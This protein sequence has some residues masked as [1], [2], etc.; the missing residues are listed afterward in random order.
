M[1]SFSSIFKSVISITAFGVL[2]F[3]VHP[4]LAGGFD[5]R[6]QTLCLNLEED[7]LISSIEIVNENFVRVWTAHE[8]QNCQVAYLNYVEKY[9]FKILGFNWDGVILESGYQ[10]MTDETTRA[11]NEVR[12]CGYSNWQVGVYK[13]TSGR[14]CGDYTSPQEGEALYSLIREEVSKPG[15]RLGVPTLGYDG[16]TVLHRHKEWSE[17]WHYQF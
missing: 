1:S 3:V 17:F 16:K 13:N 6:Y 10:P 2:M 12:W 9:K 11:L 14:N 15:F 5:G 8:D 4:V 7:N